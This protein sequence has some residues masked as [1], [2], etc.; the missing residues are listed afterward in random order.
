M[1]VT[2]QET[3]EFLQKEACKYPL[4]SK[5]IRYCFMAAD[6]IE[7]EIQEIPC[8]DGFTECCMYNFGTQP[9]NYCP[10]CGRKLK[11]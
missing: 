8:R 2:L 5:E 10:L 11:R 1:K 9:I 6:H 7:R 4:L 3:Y